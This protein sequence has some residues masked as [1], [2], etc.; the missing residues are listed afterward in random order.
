[1]L[2]TDLHNKSI[3]KKITK[4]QVLLT[5]SLLISLRIAFNSSHITSII[6]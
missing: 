5:L 1:M 3:A 4:D 2:A 6:S